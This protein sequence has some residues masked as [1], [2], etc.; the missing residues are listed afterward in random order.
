MDRTSNAAEERINKLGLDLSR[1]PDD[2]SPIHFWMQ[3]GGKRILV[4]YLVHDDYCENPIE[5]CEGNGKFI[6]DKQCFAHIGRDENGDPSIDSQLEI[7]ARLKGVDVL[8]LNN[9]DC[10]IARNMWEEALDRSEIG[11]KY[12][13]PVIFTHHGQISESSGPSIDG[14]WIP[15]PSAL[16][17]I[18][19]FP[20]EERNKK[21][22]EVFECAVEEYNKWAEGDCWGVVVD[23]FEKKACGEY[24]HV[25]DDTCWGYVGADWAKNELAD[26]MKWKIKYYRDQLKKGKKKCNANTHS[27]SSVLSPME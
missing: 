5:I 17:H 25:D 15:D 7:L 22:R 8:E 19:S 2:W 24:H 9:E 1:D 21:A 13:L 23:E 14:V 16:E 12:A 26:S 11:T 18:D 10:K 4:G 6:F 3:Q 20:E 27:R